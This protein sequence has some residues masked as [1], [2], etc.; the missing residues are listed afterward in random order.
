MITSS[1]NN[2]KFVPY[3][4]T[5][6][7]PPNSSSTY[8]FPIIQ[9]GRH[10][11]RFYFFLFAH[12]NYNMSLANFSVST[13]SHCHL[14][15]FNSKGA[16]MKEFSVYLSSNTLVIT[17]IPSNNSF[18]FLNT[19]EVVSVPESLITD[20][21]S[22]V[23]TQPK[24]FEGLLMQAFENTARENG[25]NLALFSL[26]FLSPR[27]EEVA[28]MDHGEWSPEADITKLKDREKF[29]PIQNA[30]RLP[31]VVIQA[32]VRWQ[33]NKYLVASEIEQYF[34]ALTQRAL[35]GL[36]DEQKS[37]KIASLLSSVR[38]GTPQI[39]GSPM[40]SSL[41][42][43]NL[44]L[45]IAF[46]TSCFN[47]SSALGIFDWVSMERGMNSNG[48]GIENYINRGIEN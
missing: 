16:S 5:G 3:R 41:S 37:R 27:K 32:S 44:P 9:T 29:I 6:I 11:I 1:S 46:R 19:L 39:D 36:R 14:S 22:T 10:W 47:S 20:N 15:N 33:C 28:E 18:A 31:L 4:I 26:L 17:F 43:L 7:F 48:K 40:I 38:M 13:Q 8:T 25:R 21:A 24:K 2:S 35:S 30:W 42:K 34:C 12:R 45:P 23:S